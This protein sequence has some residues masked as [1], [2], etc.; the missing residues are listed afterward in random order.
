MV[1]G[2]AEV[3]R[4]NRDL[5]DGG[6]E[7]HRTARGHDVEHVA[8]DLV[9][10]RVEGDIAR[11]CQQQ[12]DIAR[13]RTGIDRPVASKA[14][15]VKRDRDVAG[16]DHVGSDARA[17]VET[18][19]IG[20]VQAAGGDIRYEVGHLSIDRCTVL[21][22]DGERAAGDLAVGRVEHDLAARGGKRDSRGTGGRGDRAGSGDVG[23]GVGIAGGQRDGTTCDDVAEIDRQIIE[24]HHGQPATADRRVEVVD[25]RVERRGRLGD[26]REVRTAHLIGCQS[27]VDVAGHGTE[28]Y[29]AAAGIDHSGA[30]ETARGCGDVDQAIGRHDVGGVDREPIRFANRQAF[31]GSGD[32]RGQFRHIGAEGGLVL[33]S[34]V[35]DNAADELRPV[36]EVHTAGSGVDRHITRAGIDGSRAGQVSGERDVDAAVIRADAGHSDVEVVGLGDAQR[37]Q[38]RGECGGDGIDGGVQCGCRRSRDSEHV[39]ADLARPVDGTVGGSQRDV[40]RAGVDV[41]GAGEVAGRRDRDRAVFGRDVTTIDRQVAGLRHDDAVAFTGQVGDHGIDRRVDVHRVLRGIDR[42]H[43][44]PNL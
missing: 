18:V 2:S 7:I 10:S 3:V 1:D 33:G 36:G 16:R 21:G 28:Q 15:G 9:G 17:D 30:V 25:I 8:D 42:E 26:D 43:I 34:D 23:F 11:P 12:R 22:V 4:R 31:T 40:G 19:D 6:V 37:R 5:V 39:P 27:E 13:S 38:I 14:A 20:D 32:V 41:I 29:V 24:V 35:E 44:A